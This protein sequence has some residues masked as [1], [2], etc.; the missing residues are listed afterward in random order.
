MI[1]CS[2]EEAEDTA[3]SDAHP[4][5]CDMIDLIE[6]D[7]AAVEEQAPGGVPDSMHIAP[8]SPGACPEPGQA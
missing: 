7:D 8:A 3:D 2:A 5:D 4:E 1:C 6:S